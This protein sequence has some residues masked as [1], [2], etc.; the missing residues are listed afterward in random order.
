MMSGCHFSGTTRRVQSSNQTFMLTPDQRALCR[1]PRNCGPEKTYYPL[2]SI[3]RSFDR[4]QKIENLQHR[5]SLLNRTSHFKMQRIYQ[6]LTR[7]DPQKDQFLKQTEAEGQDP[8]QTGY[9]L[10]RILVTASRKAFLAAVRE[11]IQPKIY[12]TRYVRTLRTPRK[13]DGPSYNVSSS[14]NKNCGRKNESNTS[15]APQKKGSVILPSTTYI[16]PYNPSGGAGSG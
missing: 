2:P 16:S 1:P 3:F 7:M 9:E 4:N 5:Q 13:P 11:A 12:K 15:V 14:K 6:L 10:F 8:Y